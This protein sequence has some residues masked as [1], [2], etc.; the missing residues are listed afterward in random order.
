MTDENAPEN[1]HNL[2]KHEQ[3]E[4]FLRLIKEEKIPGEWEILAEAIGVTRQ[5]INNWKKLPEFQEALSEGIKNAIASME[6][7]G[8]YDWRMWREKLALL[9]KEKEKEQGNININA[10]KVLVIPSELIEKYGIKV[11]PN[12]EDS[13]Q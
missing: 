1:I 13:S 2:H 12:A 10:D 4:E 9:T 6:H 3:F 11:T 8:R 5:T 7:S